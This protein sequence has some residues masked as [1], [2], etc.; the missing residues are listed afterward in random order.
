MQLVAF[1]VLLAA[2]VVVA[3][4]E[5]EIPFASHPISENEYTPA[6][7]SNLYRGQ[8]FTQRDHT[9]PQ[10]RDVIL[11]VSVQCERR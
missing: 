5:A 10:N 6:Q 4:A 9:R 3:T 8:F 11:F 2:V 7:P 1:T